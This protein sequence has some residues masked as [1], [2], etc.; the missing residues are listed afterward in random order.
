MSD[1]PVFPSL[2]EALQLEDFTIVQGTEGRDL[3]RATVSN[4]V[5]VGL[6]GDDRISSVNGVN[7]VIVFAGDGNDRISVLRSE[8]NQIDAGAG[9]DLI[10]GGGTDVILAGAGNDRVF[11]ERGDDFV[12]GGSGDDR[13]NGGRGND[14]LL[15]GAGNDTLQGRAG[16]DVLIGGAGNDTLTGGQG[17]DVLSGGTGVNTLTGGGGRDTFELDAIPVEGNLA[18]LAIITDFT[19]QDRLSLGSSDLQFSDLTTSQF[20]DRFAV[21]STAEAG[22][23]AALDGVSA[24]SITEAS[25]A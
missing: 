8:T 21:I 9:N 17:R 3:L 11:A 10:V 4:S 14:T 16:N 12:D 22:F 6:G 25:F 19:S 5:I 24:S 2:E 15:G 1:N 20:N 7:N 13:L 23:I 18:G